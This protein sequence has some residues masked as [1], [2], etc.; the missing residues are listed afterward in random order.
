[1]TILLIDDDS[2][3]ADLYR[4]TLEEAG[5]ICWTASSGEE[6]LSILAERGLPNFIF[7]D[8]W[9]P[10]M[11]GEEFMHA[12][13]SSFPDLTTKC[14]IIGCTGF[15]PGSPAIANFQRLVP[16]LIRKGDGIDGLTRVLSSLQR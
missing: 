15:A 9:M 1:M 10:R 2:I 6:A 3:V 4:E 7:L 12:A 8:S 14:R 5:Y 13:L 16:D 11:S